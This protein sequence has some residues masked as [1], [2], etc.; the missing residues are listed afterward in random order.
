ML[1]SVANYAF[2]CL[3]DIAYRAIQPLFYSMPLELGGLG[4]SPARIGILLAT[5]GIMNGTL[6]AIWFP[7]LVEGWG[8]KRLFMT[9]M[10]MF[11]MLFAFFPLINEIARTQGISFWVYVLVIV[12][13]LLSIICDMAYGEQSPR[14]LP[15]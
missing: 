8:Q 14:F 6:Q 5:F 11:G 13:L 15:T 2:L 4:Q 9:G 7:R 1:L 10:A 12:Q 3:L